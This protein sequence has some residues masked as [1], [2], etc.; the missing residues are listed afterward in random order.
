MFVVFLKFSENKNLAADFMDAH[1]KWIKKG[2]DDDVFMVVGSLQPNL[3]GGIIA[4][5]SSYSDLEERV[6]NDPFVEKN[7]VKYEI[8]EISPSMAHDKFKFLMK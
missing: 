7:I 1:K 8:H 6:K 3:G 2:I 5:C 4:S